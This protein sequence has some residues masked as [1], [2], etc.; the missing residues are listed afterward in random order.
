MKYLI[1]IL[2]GLLLASTALA[3]NTGGTPPPSARAVAGNVSVTGTET[4]GGPGECSYVTI[5]ITAEIEGTNDLGGGN[6]QIRFSIW[7]DGSEVAFEVVSVAV[8]ETRTVNVTLTFE[9]LVGVGAPGVGVTIYDG[10]TTGSAALFSEDPFY[11]E[12]VPGSCD[13]GAPAISVPVNGPWM[14]ITLTGLLALL[15]F[16]VLRT[17]G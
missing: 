16:G 1:A 17:R 8:G 4:D 3:N 15:G 12:T 6:D 7:D 14:L 11:P 9:G 13:G 10:P 5:N 2:G